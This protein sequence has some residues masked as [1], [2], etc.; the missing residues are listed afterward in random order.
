PLDDSVQT[1][2]AGA[3]AARPQKPWRPAQSQR[4]VS[5]PAF[6]RLDSEA[7]T[8]FNSLTLCP[9]SSVTTSIEAPERS[10][11]SCKPC[12]LSAPLTNTL[13]SLDSRKERSLPLSIVITSMCRVASNLLT[14]P[15]T[16]L[17]SSSSAGLAVAL[18]L[19]AFVSSAP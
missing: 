6:L 10:A 15:G 14:L 12:L 4:D 17:S 13:T 16:S 3:R 8:I 7:G 5:Y 18:L 1:L 2:D 19:A 11:G 9:P